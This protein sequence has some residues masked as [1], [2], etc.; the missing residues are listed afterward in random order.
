MATEQCLG[1]LSAGIP[2]GL[3][4]NGEAD[5][6]LIYSETPAAVA[7]VFTRN[8]VQAA[9]VLLCRQRIQSGR[10]RGLRVDQAQIQPAVLFETGVNP[11]RLEARAFFGAHGKFLRRE[12]G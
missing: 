3:K 11:G 1:F 5:L 8:L 6:G 10:C 12:I 7:A 9:P 4:K 2:A